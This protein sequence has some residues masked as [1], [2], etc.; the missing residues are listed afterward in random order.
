MWPPRVPPSFFGI[1]FGLAGLGDVWHAAAP[2]LRVSPAVAD[3]IFIAAA[4]VWVILLAGYLAQGWQQ[5]LA[6]FG[7]PVLGPFVSLVVITPLPLAAALA[8]SA[9]FAARLLVII[10]VVLTAVLGG[11]ITGQWI[12]TKIDYDA[13]H[14]GYFLPTVAGPLVGSAAAAAV[15]L[16]DVAWTAFGTGTISWLVLGSIVLNRLFFRPALPAP[17]LPTMAIEVAPAIVAGVAYFAIDGG[18]VDFAARALGGYA[19]LMVIAQLRLV[20]VY[21][22]L[23]FSPGF[24]AFTF[25]Y[26][27]VATD[28]VLWLKAAR[29]PGA[30]TYMIVVVTLLT[31]LIV[32]IAARSIVA[33]ARGQFF[34]ARRSAAPPLPPR[35]PRPP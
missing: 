23:S 30:T 24:W 13:S 27:I 10:F 35:P 29:P 7:D 32:A 5:I 3:G 20:P 33:L 4:A 25:S 31:V 2:S 14:P 12:A 26:A 18:R 11:L 34:P 19:I 9:Y 21:A 16:H 6:D 17:L 15:G 8:P 1:P 22:R 28:A